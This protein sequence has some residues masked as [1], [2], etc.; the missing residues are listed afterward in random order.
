M[1]LIK[2]F[3]IQEGFVS[4]EPLYYI[5]SFINLQHFTTGI[6]SLFQIQYA[7][8][9]QRHCRILQINVAT[10]DHFAILYFTAY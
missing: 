3:G 9:D 6:Y 1:N 7:L 5:S 4:F 2:T 10:I 8:S